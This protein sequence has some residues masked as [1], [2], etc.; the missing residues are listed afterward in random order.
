MAL[1]SQTQENFIADFCQAAWY[2]RLMGC[3]RSSTCPLAFTLGPSPPRVSPG[4]LAGRARVSGCLLPSASGRT[5]PIDI[6]GEKNRGLY[7][8]PRVPPSWLLCLAASSG[9]GPGRVPAATPSP[10]SS[11][12]DGISARATLSSVGSLKPY[13]PLCKY[14]LIK[15]SSK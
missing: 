15:A 9:S 2:F 1:V 3:W 10:A 13:L 14:S 8:R 12:Q 6:R 4:W 11:G 5:E 7:F